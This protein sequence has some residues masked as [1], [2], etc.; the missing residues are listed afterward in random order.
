M[1]DVSDPN[2]MQ[3]WQCTL[4]QAV[5]FVKTIHGKI[6]VIYMIAM[7]S[8]FFQAGLY[9][10]FNSNRPDVSRGA[11]L[12]AS[13]LELLLNSIIIVAG[14]QGFRPVKGNSISLVVD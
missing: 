4:D 7:W 8:P 11:N 10:G 14:T 12:V 6:D 3:V 13:Q 9:S 5:P 2:Y 1:L